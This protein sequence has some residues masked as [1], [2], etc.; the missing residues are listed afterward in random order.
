MMKIYF[1]MTALLAVVCTEN[2]VTV[3]PSSNVNIASTLV[4]MSRMNRA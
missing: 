3:I 2:V 1:I 4:D